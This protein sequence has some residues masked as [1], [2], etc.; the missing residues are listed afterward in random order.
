M[1]NPSTR[2]N[3]ALFVLFF[4][5]CSQNVF[6]QDASSCEQA[7]VAST[8]IN[9]VPATGQDGYWYTYTVP[10]DGKLIVS[11]STDLWV[12]LSYNTCDNRYYAGSGIGNASF[13]NATEGQEVFIYWNLGSGSGDFEWSI[14]IVELGEG[15]NCSLSKPIV[16][17]E[18]YL[19]STNGQYWFSYLMPADGRVV[20]ETAEAVYFEI[21]HGNCT[22]E[23]LYWDASSSSG[24]S[25]SFEANENVIVRFRVEE[26]GDF[27]WTFNVLDLA[28]GDVCD[29]AKEASNGV[30]SIP[31]GA[32]NIYWFK[33]TK[34]TEGKIVLD[35]SPWRT[36]N[37]YS[38]ICGNLELIDSHYRGSVLTDVELGTEVYIAVHTQFSSATELVIEE[39]PL[40]PGDG[41]N[42][43][44]LAV[45][46]TNSL[47]ST[48]QYEY[49]YEFT[50]PAEGKLEIT[51]EANAQL[52]VYSGNCNL[53]NYEI[54]GYGQATATGLVSGEK[55]WIVWDTYS[56][57][58]FDW[59]LTVSD[60][61]PGDN[62]SLAE[63]AVEG[64]NHLP[65]T[66]LDYYWYT[67]TT[68][69]TGRLTIM[70]E[71]D[72]WVNVQYNNC[73]QLYGFASGYGDLSKPVFEAGTQ[74]FIQWNTNNGG[75]FDWS[76][77]LDDFEPGD[78]CEVPIDATEGSNAFT[79]GGYVDQWYRFVMPN[80]QKLSIVSLD[81]YSS[82]SI[83]T[84]V[85]ENL[86]YETGG[87]KGTSVT[88]LESGDEVLIRWYGPNTFGWSLVLEGYEEGDYCEIAKVAVDGT[89]ELPATS[90]QYFWYKY[91]APRDGK[92]VISSSVHKYVDVLSGDCESYYWLASG[93]EDLTVPEV[94]E[95]DE[96][97]IRWSANPGGFSWDI[98][99]EEPQLGDK[100]ALPATAQIGI[101]SMPEI[102]SYYWYTFTVEEEGMLSIR[103]ESD[104]YVNVFSNNCNNQNILGYGY[105]N[106]DVEN[107]EVGEEVLIR[108][109]YNS[110]G[111]FDWTLSYKSLTDGDICSLAVEA[112]E[113][114]NS[115][116][117]TYSFYKWYSFTMPR[118]GKLTI[119]SNAYAD[120]AVYANSCEDLTYKGN[121]YY[122]KISVPSLEEGTQILLRWSLGYEDG[123]NWT[124][125]VEDDAAGDSCDLPETAIIGT[126]HL[127]E[128]NLTY[129]WYNYIAP[130][131]GKLKISR[132]V[133]GSVNVFTGTCQSLSYYGG[134][135][136]NGDLLVPGFNEGD[137]IFIQ[138]YQ[139][140]NFDW[141]LEFVPYET[142]DFCTD[143]L[144][145][146][147]G[148][149]TTDS[150]P[151]WFKFTV[152]A[153][154]DLT[155]S[156]VGTTT[157][158]TYLRLYQS[159]GLGSFASN[160]DFGG[161]SQSEI[162]VTSLARGEEIWML[163]DDSNSIDGFDW[164]IT[165][166]SNVEPFDQTITFDAISNKTYGSQFDI[167][168]T[169][170]SDLDVLVEVISGPAVLDGSLLTLNGLG[171][172]I[173]EASQVG[174]Y[175]FNPAV[176]VQRSFTVN[177]APMV[178]KAANKTITYGDPLP[179][180]TYSISGFVNG[181]TSE[182]VTGVISI[183]TD[184]GETPNVGIYD[185]VTSG[186][187]AVN[188]NIS[189]VKGTLTVEKPSQTLTFDPLPEKAFGDGVLELV[190]IG[191]ASGNPVA[192]SSG[193]TE[194]ATVEGNLLTIAGAG[195]TTITAYQE[196]GDNYKDASVERQLIV[197]KAS[198]SVEFAELT[199][200][201]FGDEAFSLSAVSSS[202]LTVS[203]SSSNTAVAQIENG[204][205]SIKSAGE[206][207]ITAL[208][209]GD[210]NYNL[211][212]ATQ[213]LV[214]NKASQVI[215]FPEIG[216]T[217]GISNG[218]L[219][220]SATSSSGLGTS[221]SVTG[222]A[223][224][225]GKVLTLTAP[226]QVEVTATQGGNINYL[227]AEDVTMGFE[228]IDDTNQRAEQTILFSPIEDKTFRDDPFEIE[229]TASSGLDIVFIIENGPA[230]IDGFVVTL[231]GAGSVTIAANQVGDDEY[232]PAPEVTQSFMVGKATATI[233]LSNLQQSVDGTPKT[234]T[235]VVDPPFV[236]YVVTF[237]GGSDEPV[238]PGSYEVVVEIKDTNYQGSASETF[239]LSEA[240][241]V[242][243]GGL[244]FDV[245]TYPIPVVNYLTIE[246]AGLTN[247]NQ[248]A[249]KV[250][251]LIDLLGRESFRGSFV[252]D[253]NMIDLTY[254]PT[255]IYFL[256]VENE[257]GE[258]LKR[259]KVWKE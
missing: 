33:Y 127:P 137:Q 211:A 196:G 83:Y 235:V 215:T 132:E 169:S 151:I 243:E 213:L 94:S 115:I 125:A 109:N 113:G 62:C 7:V 144:D 181:E 21:L 88:G 238:E 167:V 164:T 96:M 248:A 224:L 257:K 218:A 117:N 145:A 66:T 19:P 259:V 65:E 100:C 2:Q 168:P 221:Y 178:V 28:D 141:N 44:S 107:V 29:F 183:S 129:F 203:F 193:N 30:N 250:V 160:D 67:Y 175:Y 240:L 74:L 73:E 204:I 55:V 93:Y 57:D 25:V 212:T 197:N 138:W 232:A 245:K 163:W 188:Y 40:E 228:V 233:A 230:T 111:D 68:P 126:N 86:Y 98:S 75:D 189:H 24:A 43:T 79:T 187:E 85:C 95:G 101:N 51:S 165:F 87:Q 171:E 153:E 173:I 258:V 118:D 27:N 223:T 249:N 146:G 121:Y 114:I 1:K 256:I 46:G 200:K 14:D 18:N 38:G 47:P 36:I 157:T 3:L 226:G 54:N 162:T 251:R 11:S 76:I 219:T 39:S 50:M 99:V 140:S 206:A 61:S 217:V 192:F 10:A 182:V 254:Q 252:G 72:Q 116:A 201:I 209:P 143:P 123:F 16:V 161:T 210:G 237:D 45:E 227:P 244:G 12:N 91:Q 185:I 158:D 97:F 26:G 60:L 202:G 234:P 53:L 149:N 180:L 32:P 147:V 156:S 82:C 174:D 214:I 31:Q 241:A 179:N 133:W 92:L 142:G 64:T 154:G 236:D 63:T 34:A 170:D 247:R 41:C 198:Q 172:V 128:S 120:I 216:P 246:M 84:G 155:I 103:S 20:V 90:N 231:T 205:L 9:T 23:Y 105:G 177:P 17:G 139:A 191:G 4:L 152:P 239:V 184:A 122:G 8:G 208:Q 78:I 150:A 255:G 49:W 59:D 102:S 190:A 13:A 148:T 222:P 5:F 130:S 195:T 81:Q 166:D 22:D 199:Q 242:K 194:V 110:G 15:D 70:S 89:N 52:F 71:T 229:A 176:P 220:L 253:K 159:C 124:L 69:R 80:D 6:S 77:S 104:D 58:N 112:Q 134:G 106:V 207:T 56:Y 136:G 42:S 119:E 131:S 48:E 135:Y 225:L 37:T 108:W 35:T 186:G